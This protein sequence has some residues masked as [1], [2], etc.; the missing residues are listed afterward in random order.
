MMNMRPFAVGA[1]LGLAMFAVASRPA[2]GVPMLTLTS[3]ATVVTITD[4]GAGDSNGIAGVITYI[5][6]VGANWVLNVTTGMSKPFSGT[7][8]APKM[9]LNT[10]NTTSVGAGTLTIEFTDTGF[11]TTPPTGLA[12]EALIGGTVLSKAGSSISY[13]TYADAAN[14]AFAQTTLLTSLGPFGPGAFS[15]STISS[16]YPGSL[17]FSITQ[18]LTITHGGTGTSSLD[19]ELQTVPEPSALL[20][21]GSGLVGFGYLRRRRRARA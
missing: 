10:V 16:T 21:L 13:K 19:A 9:D 6:A 15:G 17:P 8:A 7:V 18:V 14:V 4:G 1:V 5:G 11:G 3:G 2:Y 12:V 20:L